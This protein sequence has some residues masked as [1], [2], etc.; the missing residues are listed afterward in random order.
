M[1]NFTPFSLDE[2]KDIRMKILK[3]MQ[4]KGTDFYVSQLHNLRSQLQEF[5]GTDNAFSQD[6]V[7]VPLFSS[8][9]SWWQNNSETL[10]QIFQANILKLKARTALTA[11]PS[12]RPPKVR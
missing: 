8:T 7:S 12:R 11:L 6:T 9:S 2:L 3:E 10:N 1:S 5:M 4:S